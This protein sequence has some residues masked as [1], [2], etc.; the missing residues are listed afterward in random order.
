MRPLD[1]RKRHDD[2]LSQLFNTPRETHN[3]EER[4]VLPKTIL[5]LKRQELKERRNAKLD[6]IIGGGKGKDEVALLRLR[7]CI[8]ALAV[9]SGRRTAA[10]EMA[11]GRSH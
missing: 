8:C 3:A 7:I 4:R 2:E 9:R 10:A 5:K 1:T 6:E 11:V